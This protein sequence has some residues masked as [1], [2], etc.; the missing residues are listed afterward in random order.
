MWL[1]KETLLLLCFVTGIIRA[2]EDGL[3]GG[4]ALVHCLANIPLSL[5]FL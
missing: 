1:G 2:E 4:M 5:P 3:R